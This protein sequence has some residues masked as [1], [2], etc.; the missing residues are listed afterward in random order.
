MDRRSELKLEY[1]NRPKNIGIFQ[2]K[3]KKNNKIF[4]GASLSLD[5]AFNRFIFGLSY[6]DIHQNQELMKDWQE[7]G[8]EN[9]EYEILDQLKPVDDPLYDY[10]E[11][12]KTL[13]EL[14]LEKLQPYDEKG[15][16]QRKRR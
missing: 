6:G 9:F 4:V 11:D 5:K 8:P 14:W 2:V 15:Y 16:N 1:K 10:K 7:D 3:N 13:E 12:L